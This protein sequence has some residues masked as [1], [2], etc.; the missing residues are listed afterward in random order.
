[1]RFER[2]LFKAYG[3]FHGQTLDF[4]ATPAGLHV[5]YGPNEAGKSSALRA[6]T[7]LLFGIDAR[8]PDNFRHDY[9]QLRVG[10][11]LD[12]GGESRVAVMRRKGNKSTL[13]EFDP[14]TGEEYTDRPLPPDYF[15]RLLGELDQPTFLTMFGI[16]QASLRKG[17]KELS[18]GQGE[19][20]ETL[21]QATS[22]LAGVRRLL[23]RLDDEAAAL[24]KPAGHK[25]SLNVAMHDY[26]EAQKK[27]K[28][29]QVR[30]KLWQER[31]EALIQA[32]RQAQ[33]LRARIEALRGE[34]RQLNR[35]ATAIPL[36]ASHAAALEELAGLHDAPLLDADAP[37]QRVQAAAERAHAERDSREAGALIEGYERELPALAVPEALLNSGPDIEALRHDLTRAGEAHRN[38]QAVAALRSV[39]QANLAE[40]ARACFGAE[41][42]DGLD[43]S[44]R[45]PDRAALAR[46][47]ELAA[48]LHA[49]TEAST[50]LRE[51]VHELEQD[52]A[53]AQAAFA[54]LPTPPDFTALA[55]TLDALK[56]QGDPETQAAR[57]AVGL[58][59]SARRLNDEASALGATDAKALR[60]LQ[61]P[62]D[63][64]IEHYRGRFTQHQQSLTELASEESKVRRDLDNALAEMGGLEAAGDV[65][66]ADT[67]DAA[68][69]ARD[70]QWFEMRRVFIDGGT[71]TASQPFQPLPSPP[72][73]GREE[74]RREQESP[75]HEE[76]PASYSPLTRGAG[77]VN[78]P[79]ESTH[80]AHLP[81]LYETA[82]RRADHLA[83]TLRADT[84]RATEYATLVKRTA[85]MRSRLT[86]IAAERDRL[87]Q[88]EAENRAAW[89]GRLAALGLAPVAPD[90]FKDW[91][92][93]RKRVLQRLEQHEK[94]IAA[95]HA[96]EDALRH[97]RATLADALRDAGQDPEPLAA[98]PWAVA[99]EQAG[100]IVTEAQRARNE[101]DQA[102]R[103]AERLARDWHRDRS[104][105]DRAA[106]KEADARG[107]WEATLTRLGLTGTATVAETEV[108]IEALDRLRDA[109]AEARRHDATLA[110]ERGFLDGH[111]AL[112]TRLATD[113][114]RPA[115]SL[116]RIP[117]FAEGLYGELD[118]GRAKAQRHVERLKALD[119]QRERLARAEARR[120]SASATLNRLARAAG[121]ADAGEL[122]EAEAR[123]A[124]RRQLTDAVLGIEAQLAAQ[125]R[126]PL[127]ALLAEAEG[128]TADVVARRLADIQPDMA[129]L[130]A[131]LKA[132]HDAE[133]HARRE[134]QAIDGG[135]KAA[136]L[137]EEAESLLARIRHE[138]ERYARLR[139]ARALLERGIQSFRDQAHGPLLEK[140]DRYFGLLTSGRYSGLRVDFEDDRQVLAALR[141]DGVGL[142]VRDLSEGTADQ[143]Y[144]ALRLA[145]IELNIDNGQAVPVVLDDLLLTFD[146]ERSAQ[147]LRA[148]ASLGERTQV[149]L[150]THH[151][152]VVEIAR[153]VLAG[154]RLG[155]VALG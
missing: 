37:G 52:A 101:R 18:E 152:H 49:A 21:F 108:R 22:G 51:Q 45:L 38:I 140:A 97:A 20:G 82:V 89:Q 100:R 80:I 121:C 54:E 111:A 15:A 94:E 83:D 69:A 34:E 43:L 128:Q 154:G 48:D 12:L 85:Q 66:T 84:A 135:A 150:F 30:P 126:L 41:A 143:L 16:N 36:L 79:S 60:K 96:A 39:C 62:L 71:Q 56:L 75:T 149:L 29:A 28:D 8:T 46:V 125:C 93:E 17:G 33:A 72:Y 147:A 130:D 153:G 142:Q 118:E 131:E 91:L 25:P 102:R 78:P 23:A 42:P 7:A 92:A 70:Q 107:E 146:D 112:A 3:P 81:D 95:H 133:S 144:L 138:A 31:Q 120:L 86:A 57:L 87:R 50:G 67:V 59:E 61:V 104:R 19:L 106:N 58:D 136:E 11:V 137:R 74:L 63:G 151:R 99:L 5:I 148:L 139:L 68:R 26:D 114:D 115:P 113:L 24:F 47:R 105:L 124:R 27:L 40:L 9:A 13:F 116:E 77:G 65:V 32:E 132:A 35:L 117:A 10:A 53:A 44:A 73:Q 6:I 122:P 2:L 1:M 14:A 145:A 110:T 129:A 98:K 55:A 109:L 103:D 123:S 88:A 4:S 64:E 134:L 119:E 76:S 127:A 155:V 141:P 90:V